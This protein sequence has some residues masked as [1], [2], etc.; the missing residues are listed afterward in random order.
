MVME[1]NYNVSAQGKWVLQFVELIQR[2][3][4]E[5]WPPPL[6]IIAFIYYS[7][8]LIFCDKKLRSYAYREN[9]LVTKPDD[10]PD[11]KKKKS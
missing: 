9:S 6:N 8:A 7:T 4:E 10:Y 11:L 2:C 5:L 1:N 3:E